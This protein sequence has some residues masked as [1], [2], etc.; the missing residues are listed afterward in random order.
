L[1]GTAKAPREI[2]SASGQL[3]LYDEKFGIS[4]YLA[5]IHTQEIWYPNIPNDDP[6]AVIEAYRQHFASQFDPKE[7]FPVLLGGE[8]SVTLSLVPSIAKAHPDLGVILVDAHADLRD[9]YQGFKFSHACV[10]RRLLERF[11][12]ALFG[13]RSLS[14][15]EAHLITQKGIPTVFAH[16]IK[17]HSELLSAFEQL[18]ISMP[19]K[20][21]L[22]IDVDGL[23]ASLMPDVGTPEPFGLSWLGLMELIEAL[24]RK[25][26]LVGLDLVEHAPLSRAKASSFSLARMLYRAMGLIALSRGWI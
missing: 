2:L 7:Q 5:G 22:S 9:S 21:Y 19:Q 18:L 17:A 25:K 15:E 10:S 26:R 20:I 3:E 4:P 12:I 1:K 11:S 6:E 16:Q 23:D 24:T 13:I 14:E 8:H